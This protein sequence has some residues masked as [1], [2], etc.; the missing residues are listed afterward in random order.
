M[1]AVEAPNRRRSSLGLAETLAKLRQRNGVAYV[2]PGRD[3]D[4]SDELVVCSRRRQTHIQGADRM[5]PKGAKLEP[6]LT[7]ALPF[8]EALQR[9]CELKT[10]PSELPHRIRKAAKRKRRKSLRKPL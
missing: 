3:H 1:G 10:V 2:A 4:G 6:K 8:V 9:F 7:I 5:N